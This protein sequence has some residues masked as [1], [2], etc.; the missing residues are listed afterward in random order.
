M[1]SPLCH[2]LLKASTRHQLPRLV[3]LACLTPRHP[4]C[5]LRF[6]VCHTHHHDAGLHHVHDPAERCSSEGHGGGGCLVGWGLDSW[7]LT[8]EDMRRGQRGLDQGAWRWSGCQSKALRLGVMCPRGIRRWGPID[9]LAACQCDLPP[10][11]LAPC[12]AAVPVSC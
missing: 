4:A 6:P 9:D 2:L 8:G 11:M 5:C 12:L 10:S 3:T 7:A 1:F